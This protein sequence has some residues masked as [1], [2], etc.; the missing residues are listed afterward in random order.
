[1]RDPQIKS[2]KE[3]IEALFKSNRIDRTLSELNAV[4][5][6][7]KLMGPTIS[8]YTQ[9]ISIRNRKLYLKISSPA[10][11]NELRYSKANILHLLNTEAGASIIDDVVF[12]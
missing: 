5:A 10:L 2:L 4:K 7:E 3:A 6:W 12:V 9:D 11:I 8:K 1:M